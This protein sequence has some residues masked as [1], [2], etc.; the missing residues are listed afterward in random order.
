LVLT[1][2]LNIY[3]TAVNR[4]HLPT[5]FAC[6]VVEMTAVR[7]VPL[8]GEESVAIVYVRDSAIYFRWGFVIF[9]ASWLCSSRCVDKEVIV[10]VGEMRHVLSASSAFQSQERDCE[11]ID[12]S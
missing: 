2:P 8:V 3:I 5:F 7:N 1:F 10:V 9:G 11:W 4:R 6:F 12:G